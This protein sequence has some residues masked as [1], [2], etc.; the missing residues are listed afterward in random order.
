MENTNFKNDIFNKNKN[1]R[2][3]DKEPIIIK[4]YE[5]AFQILSIIIPMIFAAYLTGLI[6]AIFDKNATADDIYVLSAVF[7][8]IAI[9]FILIEYAGFKKS[10]SFI[11]FTNDCIGFYKNNQLVKNVD[12]D[13][14]SK[15]IAK[16]LL[17]YFTKNT[18]FSKL[19]IV[20][21]V[22]LTLLSIPILHIWLLFVFASV[23]CNCFYKFL[24]CILTTKT[25]D[26]RFSMFPAIIINEPEFALNSGFAIPDYFLLVIFS[27]RKYSEIKEYFLNLHNINID[28]VEKIYF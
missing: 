9:F 4:N 12:L 6:V 24:F 7:F 3:Y 1:L 23:F 20:S 16:P 13:N 26:R 22:L 11:K 8:T 15:N 21:F 25:G 2:N 10:K 19:H 5:Q 14:L 18:K 28:N 17:A 27:K